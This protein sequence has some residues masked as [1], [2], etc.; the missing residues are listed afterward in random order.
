MKDG[1]TNL[2]KNLFF[3]VLKATDEKSRNRSRIRRSVVRIYGSGSYKNVMGAQRCR[4]ADFST[5]NSVFQL[6][7]TFSASILLAGLSHVTALALAV[8]HS[9]LNRNP[10]YVFPKMKLR[11]LV[12]N[13]CISSI[14]ERFVYSQDWSAYLAAAK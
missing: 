1:C 5:R 6:K 12:P 2:D 10:I 11:G 3:C 4:K 13:S 14:C 8:R 9:T 7:I